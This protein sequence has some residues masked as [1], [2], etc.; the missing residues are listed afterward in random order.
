MKRMPI[1]FDL[2]RQAID[3]AN[4]G[5]VIAE[6]EGDDTIV[7]Y[8]NDAFERL[9][10]YSEDEILYQDCRFLQGPEQEQVAERE[11]IR[12]A[13]SDGLPCRVRLRNYR[14]D[15]TLF[16]NELSIA[17]IRSHDENLTYFIGVQKDVTREVEMERELRAAQARL[18]EL[19]R[20]LA[21]ARS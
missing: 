15:G 18:A 7:I 17:P 11:L 13:I 8:V 19:E 14:K 4:D 20:Q 12:Q 2:L 1:S 9:T 5:L 16:W 10:G 21:M 3:M 6:Q